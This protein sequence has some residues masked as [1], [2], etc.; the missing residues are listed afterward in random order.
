[1]VKT[2]VNVALMSDNVDCRGDKHSENEAC[3]R[4]MRLREDQR[5]AAYGPE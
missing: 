4:H 2:V 5:G 3:Q 1:M